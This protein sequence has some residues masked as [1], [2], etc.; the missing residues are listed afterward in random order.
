MSRRGR[1]SGRVGRCAATL[2]VALVAVLALPGRADDGEESWK[3]GDA[4][5][6]AK[7][8]ADARECYLAALVGAARRGEEPGFLLYRLAC[9][10]EARGETRSAWQLCDRALRRPW[11]GPED[12]ASARREAIAKLEALAPDPA[13]LRTFREA[14]S[15]YQGALA[16]LKTFQDG[17]VRLA[18]VEERLRLDPGDG[19]ARG[20]R[21]PDEG[22]WRLEELEW[23][24][25]RPRSVAVR[26]GLREWTWRNGERETLSGG[27]VRLSSPAG[28]EGRLYVQAP[29]HGAFAFAVELRAV[30][31]TPPAHWGFAFGDDLD[32]DE[33]N[34]LRVQEPTVVWEHHAAGKGWRRVAAAALPEDERSGTTRM[35]PER[36][37]SFRLAYDAVAG[38]VL[39]FRDDLLVAD[40]RA[41][42]PLGAG[43]VGIVVEGGTLEARRATLAVSES[44]D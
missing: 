28:T 21:A 30:G 20:A 13:A 22:Q 39:L 16:R 38:R 2:G 7:R 42:A 6:A 23:Q 36:P 41:P 44:V 24:L 34:A 43:R 1:Y 37:C 19:E 17:A 27:R 11:G 29:V 35:L 15:G 25:A 14:L 4:H 33:R 26:R 18:A 32:G 5:F 9:A 3:I 40:L 31:D 12:E 10:E 8:Y